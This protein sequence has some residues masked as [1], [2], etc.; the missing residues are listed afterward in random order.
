MTLYSKT[1]NGPLTPF[2]LSLQVWLYPRVIMS[3]S[4]ENTS[5]YADTVIMFNYAGNN[6]EWL[7]NATTKLNKMINYRVFKKSI[8]HFK[9][10]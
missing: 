7:W 9:L 4:H 6:T 5:M 8:D 3:K 2:L 1:P 10:E